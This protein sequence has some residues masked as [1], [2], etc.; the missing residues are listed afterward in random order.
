MPHTLFQ[1]LASKEVVRSERST[2]EPTELDRAKWQLLADL[3]N[4]I[5]SSHHKESASYLFLRFR[6]GETESARLL[7]GLLASAG[8]Q[9][10]AIVDGL[11][12]A[13]KQKR[14]ESSG[15]GSA[16]A[17]TSLGTRVF[18]HVADMQVVS[19]RD[20]QLAQ[21][22]PVGAGDGDGRELA[23]K[24]VLSVMLSRTG[25]EKLGEIAPDDV[26]FREGM[27]ARGSLLGDHWSDE[28]TQKYGLIDALLVV[29]FDDDSSPERLQSLRELVASCVDIVHTDA[30]KVLRNRE[31]RA[32][33]RGALIEPF[34]FADG[35]SQPRFHERG[36]GSQPLPLNVVLAADPNGRTPHAC[37]SYFAFRKLKQN[38]ES[39][40]EQ[41]ARVAEV[42]GRTQEEILEELV[43]RRRDGRP[44]LG[45][46]AAGF[47]DDPKGLRCPFHAHVRRVN[48]QGDVP[49]H[50]HVHIARRGMPYGPNLARRDDG[51]PDFSGGHGRVRREDGKSDAP[52]VGLL[53]FAAQASIERQFETIQRTW[54]NSLRFPW[55]KM[56]GADV[57]IGQLGPGSTN[58]IASVRKNPTDGSLYSKGIDTAWE[59]VVEFLGGEYLFAPSIGFLR[60][61]LA[62]QN[63]KG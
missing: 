43:G 20:L 26:A 18:A 30:G 47:S 13:K 27:H 14:K 29:A 57:L 28:A 24:V 1:L 51:A 7:L 15:A 25:Y 37:G 33:G 2:T 59:P 21:R 4:N 38:V 41:A 40:Y 58:R 11:R 16:S 17:L 36:P 45:L 32:S 3:Q 63:D 22:T 61:L 10:D 12:S 19:E 55:G 48:P 56:G 52:E 35:V 6:A 54:A 8:G 60:G 44:L 5:L 23:P 34:G 46:D 50:E 53:F 31:P 9:R 49:S 42:C 39:F 62:D